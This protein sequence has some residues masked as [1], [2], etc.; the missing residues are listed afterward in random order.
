MPREISAVARYFLKHEGEITGKVMRRKKCS[1][2]TQGRVEI[3]ARLKLY[4][5]RTKMLNKAKELIS[6]MFSVV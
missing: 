1:R 2:L 3:P 4:H 5:P 6:R